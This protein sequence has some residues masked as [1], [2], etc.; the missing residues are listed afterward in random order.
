MGVKNYQDKYPVDARSAFF[1]QEIYIIILYM[2]FYSD[3]CD[4]YDKQ[5]VQIHIPSFPEQSL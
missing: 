5:K 4:R 1:A 2:K 3:Q